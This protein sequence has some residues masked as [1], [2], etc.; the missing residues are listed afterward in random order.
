MAAFTAHPRS[1]QHTATYY[2]NIPEL[3]ATV[4]QSQRKQFDGMMFANAKA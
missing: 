2:M 1:N 4:D 3:I